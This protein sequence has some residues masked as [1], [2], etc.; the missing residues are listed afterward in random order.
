M[1]KLTNFKKITLILIIFSVVVFL[2]QPKYKKLSHK[3]TAHQELINSLSSQLEQLKTSIRR[4]NKSFLIPNI[5]KKLVSYLKIFSAYD[6]NG[7]I[8]LIRHG[9]ENDGGY[10]IATKAFDLSDVLMGYGI[11]DDNSFEDMFSINYNKPSYG[12][13]CGIDKIESKSK[14]FTLV[15][16]CISSD[17]SLLI[18]ENSSNKISS[19]NSQ[20]D[21]LGLAG[22]KIFIKMDIEVAEYEALDEIIQYHENVTGIALEVHYDVF[23]VKKLINLLEKL[24]KD[25]VLLHIHG[26]NN[27]PSI[28]ANN[29]IGALPSVIELSYIN[30]ALVKSYDISDNQK[31]Q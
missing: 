17:S 14:L 15:N 11:N 24:Q 2:I 3:S 22:K 25:F 12:F 31:F 8:K 7:S 20:I 27:A 16:Q 6:N 23:S 9:R 5:S 21:E 28:F 19:F 30:K 10:I 4:N 26:N 1:F 18:R 13:D 29:V